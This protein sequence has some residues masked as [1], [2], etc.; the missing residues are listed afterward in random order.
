MPDNVKHF[1][2]QRL[3]TMQL[4]IS[5]PPLF[6]EEYFNVISEYYIF[7]AISSFT[8]K[9]EE[10]FLELFSRVVFEKLHKYNKVYHVREFLK[11]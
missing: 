1:T 11:N 7:H 10:I 4:K 9:N 5:T 3:S 8:F 2:S 6:N